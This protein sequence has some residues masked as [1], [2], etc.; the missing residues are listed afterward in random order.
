MS[1]EPVPSFPP[2]AHSGVDV[3]VIAGEHSGDEHASRMVAALQ[4]RNPSVRVAAIGGPRLATAGAQLL[5]DLTSTSVVGFVEVVRHYG[6]FRR[7]FAETL[8]WI[9]E[10]QPRTVCFVDYPGFN[11]RLAKA[12]VAAK[13]ARKGGGSVRLVYY[14]SPQ[15]W[16]WKPRRRH[17]MARLL[18]ALAV[19]FPFEV[20][21]YADTDLPVRFVGH[22]F[23]APDFVPSLVHLSTAPVL[24]LPG[25][26]V[27]AVRRIAPMLLEGF[28]AYLRRHPEARAQM[29]YPSR[30]VREVLEAEMETR[31][32]L[33]GR[34]VMQS[35]D[36]PAAASAVLTSSGT[37]S[38]SC[39]LAGIPGAIAY[40][41]HSATYVM[42]KFVVKVPY[43]GIANLI[44][45]QPIYPEFVQDAASPSV[46]A[47]ELADCA[48]NPARLEHTRARCAEL[49]QLLAQPAN[50]D[51]ANW[52][53]EQIA[54]RE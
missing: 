12:L 51:A 23:L 20:Q 25:S 38:L 40:R 54:A 3:L 4:R 6:F 2:P 29:V 41:L 16:A 30:L 45:P 42:A 22:P 48:E 34:V 32:E 33:A 9:K 47:A 13:L 21:S 36:V 31:P 50:G 15:I 44:L 5:F 43:I 14:I 7:V 27:A 10:H 18:D 8:R 24:L 39:A 28:T 49:R 1:T 35:N 37:M 19:I 52:L 26:R 11:L 17:S 53:A 46:L